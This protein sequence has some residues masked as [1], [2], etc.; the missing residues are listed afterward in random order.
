MP[1]VFVWHGYVQPKISVDPFDMPIEIEFV[2]QILLFTIGGLHKT[3]QNLVICGGLPCSAVGVACLGSH[4]AFDTARWGNSSCLSRSI[5]GRLQHFTKTRNVLKCILGERSDLTLHL[6]FPETTVLTHK[7]IRANE[8]LLKIHK[9]PRKTWQHLREIHG[10]P[11]C[12]GPLHEN[13]RSEH[14]GSWLNTHA[15][16]PNKTTARSRDILLPTIHWSVH[17]FSV[18]RKMC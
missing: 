4:L 17:W 5:S 14:H 10:N 15:Y 12:V 11:S 9:I 3:I 2:F 18:V 7:K 1:S 6:H 8:I 16:Q 13:T